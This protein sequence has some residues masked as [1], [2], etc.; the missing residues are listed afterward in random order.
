MTKIKIC[1]LT[2]PT[3][4]DMV[5]QI[6][7]EYIGFVFAHSRRQVSET[8]AR[9]LKAMLDPAITAVGVFVNEHI[10]TIIRLCRLGVVD[11]IQLHGDEDEEYIRQ[12][13]SNVDN[14]IIKAVRVRS[15]WDFIEADH[16]ACDYL[17]F[18]AYHKDQYGGSGETF[19]WT[20][21]G[22]VEKPFFLAGGING[23]NVTDAI[24]LTSPY[25]IDVSSGVETDGFKDF[26]KIVDI[27]TKIR[28]VSICQKED[29]ESMEDNIFLKH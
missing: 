14:P 4:I 2:R 18:D 26:S 10:D 23:D 24:S 8:T 29:S 7:P 21:I 1:G 16:Y 15:T 12:L 11:V 25:C 20:Y 3:D 17:L 27:I 9:K 19:D 6:C 22:K 13:K 5:N 28:S